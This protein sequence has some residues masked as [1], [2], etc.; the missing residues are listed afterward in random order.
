MSIA[1]S[2]DRRAGALVN[3]AAEELVLHVRAL[4]RKL[5]GDDRAAL[6][7]AFA[8]GLLDAK[9][10]MRKRVVQRLKSVVPG[11]DIRSE[12]VDPARGA[13]LSALRFLGVTRTDESRT[14]PTAAA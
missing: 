2:G 8:G 13:V 12:P 14:A 7:V 9:S 11:A 6:R 1:E 10:I 3:L 4:A 5:F